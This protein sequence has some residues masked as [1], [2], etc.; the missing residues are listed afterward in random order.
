LSVFVSRCPSWAVLV[1]GGILSVHGVHF[2]ASNS[3]SKLAQRNC[4]LGGEVS[5]VVVLQVFS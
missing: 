4:N 5:E 2:G 1:G 3:T